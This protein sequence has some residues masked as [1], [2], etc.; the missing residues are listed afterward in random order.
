MNQEK[1]PRLEQV[2]NCERK[3]VTTVVAHREFNGCTCMICIHVELKEILRT[4]TTDRHIFEGL[5]MMPSRSWDA[6]LPFLIHWADNTLGYNHLLENESTLVSP[7]FLKSYVTYVSQ[8][9]YHRFIP[10]PARKH[11][12]CSPSFVYHC[13]LYITPAQVPHHTLLT[14]H[15]LESQYTTYA[16]ITPQ[17]SYS[18]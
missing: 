2:C 14:T 8:I 16:E 3:S 13:R 15:T 12:L 6:Y 10:V 17:E 7:N 5:V 9:K 4:A 18:V 1:C 11:P